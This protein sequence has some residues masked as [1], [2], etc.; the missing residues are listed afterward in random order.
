MTGQIQLYQVTVIAM[1]AAS[2]YVGV[3]GMHSG[4][5]VVWRSDWLS[6]PPVWAVTIQLVGGMTGEPVNAARANITIPFFHA[7]MTA[8]AYG[9]L[10][11]GPPGYVLLGV[12]PAS[13][14]RAVQL[15]LGKLGLSYEEHGSRFLVPSEG[16]ELET[17]V[18]S[19]IGTAQIPGL[20]EGAR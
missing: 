5:A 9:I 1:A 6:T 2:L 17:S 12:A 7:A 16:F 14:R 4:R 19:L 20:P 18:Q 8:G 3:R 10:S 13:V 11:W 15:A